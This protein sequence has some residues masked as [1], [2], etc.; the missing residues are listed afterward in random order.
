MKIGTKLVLALALPLISIVLLF[1]YLNLRRSQ[2]L[3]RQELTREGRSIARIAQMAMED[4]LRDRQLEDAR[5]LVDELTRYERVLGIRLFDPEG[6]LIYQSA[7]LEP[8]PEVDAADLQRV[9]RE[10]RP[11][12]MHRLAGSS[13]V[14]AF[15]LPLTG[16]ENVPLGAVQVLQL[17]SF[18]DEAARA[19]R[20]SI[21]TITGVMILATAIVILLVT[22]VSVGRPIEQLV[23]SLREVGS[24]DLRA[25]A[26]AERHDEFGR[27]A[28]EFNAMAMRLEASQRSL[29]AEQE[30]RR[31]AEARLRNAER[32]ASLGQ[33]A[34]GLAHEIGT[35]LNVIG[36]RADSLLRK[37][38]D[39]AAGKSLRIIVSQID[40]IA[41]TVRGM[42]DFARLRQ[43]RLAPTEV[44]NVIDKV[45]ELLE[46]RLEEGRVRV[47]PRLPGGLPAVLA[48]ADQLQQVFLNLATNA[49]DAMPQGGTLRIRAE[50]I[51]RTHPER[52]GPPRPFLAIAFEDTGAGIAREHLNRVFDPFFSTKD[53]GKGTGLGLSV[54]YGI[55]KEHGG[56]ID[57]E[58]EAGRGARLRVFLPLETPAAAG[59]EARAS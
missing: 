58:S 7:G 54:S 4:Y 50:R 42:L 18:I 44:G 49:L 17:E 41:R 43:P 59:R 36:G 46:Q 20:N 53:V 1:G 45:L 38:G 21:A 2:T 57:V 47:E 34:A 24:G 14:I 30:E 48:D 11:V 23:R 25:R 28:Q 26:P 51:E 9:L 52:N 13:P 35:P 22:R 5:Q 55:V 10:R 33:L 19:A 40:R 31:R 15:I 27:L 37:L 32:L 12:E 29:L 39:E 8:G 16:A 56:F 6:R 3:L